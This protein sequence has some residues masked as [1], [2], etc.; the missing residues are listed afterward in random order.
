MTISQVQD[1]DR[2]TKDTGREAGIL[3][4]LSDKYSC[5]LS[6]LRIYIVSYILS[7]VVLITQKNEIMLHQNHALTLRRLAKEAGFTATTHACFHTT[8]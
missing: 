1:N 5:F 8:A 2:V 4:L 6:A 7:T 3:R